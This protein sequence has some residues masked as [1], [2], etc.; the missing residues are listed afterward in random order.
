MVH[1]ILE[2]DATNVAAVLS[3][4]SCDWS[5]LGILF[6]VI[7]ETMVEEFNS[8]RV[9]FCPHSYNC[10]ADKLAAFGMNSGVDGHSMWLDHAPDFVVPL[11]SGDVPGASQ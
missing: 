3:S 7:R 9:L 2:T 1:V 11:V 8:C 6:S 5:Q 10:V 4:S